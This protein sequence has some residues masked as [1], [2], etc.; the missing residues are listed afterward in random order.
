MDADALVEM[1]AA[2]EQGSEHPVGKAVYEHARLLNLPVRAVADLSVV[3]GRGIAGTVDGVPYAVGNSGFMQ[4]IHYKQNSDG[5]C[6]L[7]HLQ[8]AKP[9]AK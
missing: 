9:H 4:D 6:Q 3:P 7:I 2:L 8:S 5:K 1:A